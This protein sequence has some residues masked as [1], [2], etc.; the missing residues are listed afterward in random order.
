MA[1]MCLPEAPPGGEDIDAIVKYPAL[2]RRLQRRIQRMLMK[3]IAP[4]GEHDFVVGNLREMERDAR[5]D[6][7]RKVRFCEE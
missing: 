5:R 4:H 2:S 1:S 3:F 7:I 6:A